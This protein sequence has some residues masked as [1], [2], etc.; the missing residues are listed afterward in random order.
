VIEGYS[1]IKKGKKKG[2]V[3]WQHTQKKKSNTKNTSLNKPPNNE[4]IA[5][6]LAANLE[7]VV[8]LKMCS[9]N[10]NKSKDKV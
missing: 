8:T 5:L 6:L 10:P 7:Y 4:E 3:V 1:P 9:T 2:L